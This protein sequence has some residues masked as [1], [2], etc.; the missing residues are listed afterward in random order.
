MV[1]PPF[2]I[3]EL[4]MKTLI[5]LAFALAFAAVPASAHTSLA[6]S[7]PKSGAELAES[8]SVIEIRFADAAKLTSVV[9][10]G[11]D[12]KER[13]LE[14]VAGDKPNSF[15][16]TQPALTSGRN[17]VKWKALSKDGHVISGTLTFTVKPSKSN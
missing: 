1:S 10:V 15:N 8:P 16:V 6:S 2:G 11:T 9:A 17:E 3:P 14:F 13:R 5:S 7:T 12:K 4:S